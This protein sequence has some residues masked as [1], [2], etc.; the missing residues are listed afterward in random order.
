[1]DRLLIVLANEKPDILCIT[2]HW[3]TEEQ[4]KNLAIPGYKLIS[5]ISRTVNVLGEC[6]VYLKSV[7]KGE[8]R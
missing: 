2:E 3:K 8:N 7:L 1:M 6:A 4:L 5:L